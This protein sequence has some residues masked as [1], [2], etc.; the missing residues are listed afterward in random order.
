[1]NVT[2]AVNHIFKVYLYKCYKSF[3]AYDVC[4]TVTTELPTSVNVGVC[5]F[6]FKPQVWFHG[7]K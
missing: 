3:I 2:R 7:Y 1:M 4:I 6:L 5:Y